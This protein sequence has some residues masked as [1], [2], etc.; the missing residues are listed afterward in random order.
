M[1]RRGR[2][3]PSQ[4]Q[5]EGEEAISLAFREAY[6]V[7]K[8]EK[9]QMTKEKSDGKMQAR[10]SSKRVQRV[11]GGARSGGDRAAV[12]PHAREEQA[13]Q[14]P[15]HERAVPQAEGQVEY[16]ESQ[17]KALLEVGNRRYEVAYLSAGER[18][19]ILRMCKMFVHEQQMMIS[20]A[21]AKYKQ[22]DPAIF[23]DHKR[24]HDLQIAACDA[25]FDRFRSDGWKQAPEK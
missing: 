11:R 3:D 18:A 23:A 25:L 13:T 19:L 22:K 8:E 7:A 6:P 15:A 21:H 10:R 2:S 17:K 16:H 14:L 4:E 1:I 20:Q 24:H 5:L 12:A 9:K